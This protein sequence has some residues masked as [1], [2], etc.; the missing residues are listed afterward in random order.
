[1][2][3]ANFQDIIHW[4]GKATY[5]SNIKNITNLYNEEDFREHKV[6]L[7]VMSAWVKHKLQIY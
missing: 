4:I 1:M 5:S 7:C 2:N 6:E 3:F